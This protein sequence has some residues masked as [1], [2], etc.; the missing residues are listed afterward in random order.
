MSVYRPG[1]NKSST[2]NYPTIRPTL[3]LDFANT[4]TLDPRITFTRSSAGS[5]VGADGLIKYAGVNEARFDHDPITGESLGLLIEESRQNL[6][7]Y[8]EQLN[9]AAWG[10]VNIS[11]TTDSISSP[12]GTVTAEKLIV[13]NAQNGGQFF[14]NTSLAV[15]TTYTQSIFLKAGEWN[16]AFVWLNDGAGVGYVVEINLSNG[17]ARNTY[18]VPQTSFSNFSYS[19]VPYSNGWY[20]VSMTATTSSTQTF[21][22]V[23]IYPSNIAWTTGD[24]GSEYPIGN[25]TSGIYAWGAQLEAGSFPTSYIP[26]VASSRTRAADSA[27]ITGKNFSSWYRQDEGTVFVSTLTKQTH[28]G[29]NGFPRKLAISDNTINTIIEDY[30]RV[31]SVYTDAGYNV[32]SAGVV[33]ATTDTNDQRNGQSSAI[34]Y[35]NNNFALSIGGSL[36]N[37]D[38][39]GTVP[40]VTQLSLGARPGN[41]NLL[42]GTIRCLTYWPKRLPDAQLQVLTR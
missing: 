33:Q 15:S 30:Y 16:Y 5:Y 41:N 18:S 34:G 37:N 28:G 36:I 38:T 12:T 29:A 22:Q 26:T 25:G 2:L 35:A 23:R 32:A 20:R 13:N 10:K 39:S 17:S 24:F 8:S 42:N 31:L 21:W 14:R 6:W 3:N 27:S 7:T 1:T 4:K 19:V 40:T 11:T 9:D